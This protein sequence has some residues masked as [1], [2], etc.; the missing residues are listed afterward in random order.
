MPKITNLN[1]ESGKYIMVTFKC[2][3]VLAS[4]SDIMINRHKTL[5]VIPIAV[6]VDILS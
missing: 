1:S 2:T 6:S 4:V 5:L 3:I